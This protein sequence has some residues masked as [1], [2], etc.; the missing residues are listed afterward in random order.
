MEALVIHAP[1]E[2]SVETIETP[3]PGPGQRTLRRRAV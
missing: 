3:E 1:G 2:L